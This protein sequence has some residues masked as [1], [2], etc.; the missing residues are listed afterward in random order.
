MA[1]DVIKIQAA[2][3]FSVAMVKDALQ[4]PLGLAALLQ[5]IVLGAKELEDFEQLPPEAA[6]AWLLLQLTFF[7]RLDLINHDK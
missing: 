4:K 1:G 6:S 7:D 5:R 3:D 2:P